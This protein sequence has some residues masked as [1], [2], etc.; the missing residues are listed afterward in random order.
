[1]KEFFC[2]VFYKKMVL[3]CF[4]EFFFF[5]VLYLKLVFCCLFVKNIC[6]RFVLCGICGVMY[7]RLCLKVSFFDLFLKS[8]C[9]DI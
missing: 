5:E 2:V 3:K 8:L 4:L 6:V 1:M 7:I 9:I